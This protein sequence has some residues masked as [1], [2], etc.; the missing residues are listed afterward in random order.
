MRATDFE[1]DGLYLS[2]FGC[3]ICTFDENNIE[4]IA[5]GS[6]I[7]FN[8]TQTQRGQLHML[9]STSYDDCIET[10]FSI[11]KNPCTWNN[12]E[13]LYFTLQEQRELVRWL[14]RHQFLK[15][16]LIDDAYSD[17]YFEGSFNVEKIELHGNVIGMHLFLTTNRPFALRETQIITF[18]ISVPDGQYT[19]YDTS[20]EIGSSCAEIEITCRQSG[21]LIITNS[22]DQRTTEIKGCMEG[23]IITMKDLIIESSIASHQE[24]I[25]NDFNFHFIQITNS[26]K[27]RANTLTFS[28]PCSVVLKYNPSMKVGI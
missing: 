12:N 24:T 4:N 13:D 11:C 17:L 7:T 3:M 19:I 15:F 2:D 9:A 20:D 25:M 8:K 5:A 21:E 28:L 22:L 14:N 27:T 18:D 16:K 10:E 23:E 1:Y 6:Q 26:Y